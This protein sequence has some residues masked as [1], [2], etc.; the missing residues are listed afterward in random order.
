MNGASQPQPVLSPLVYVVALSS[1][2][3]LL[4]G[5]AGAVGGAS[6]LIQICN[7]VTVAP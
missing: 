3:S 6:T 1:A 7:L 2:I 4:M 5:G